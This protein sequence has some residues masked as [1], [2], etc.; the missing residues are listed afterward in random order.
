MKFYDKK[1]SKM[2][3]YILNYM[4]VSNFATPYIKTERK[5]VLFSK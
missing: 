2:T 5:S 4:P 3:N 1:F